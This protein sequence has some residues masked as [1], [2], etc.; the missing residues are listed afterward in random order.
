MAKAKRT[1]RQ[2]QQARDEERGWKATD[3]ILRWRKE[4]DSAGEVTPHIRAVE[5]RLLIVRTAIR[6]QLGGQP[7]PLLADLVFLL[8]RASDA[9][10][11]A[12]AELLIAV[13]DADQRA[14]IEAGLCEPTV[15]CDNC[16]HCNRC[17]HAHTDTDTDAPPSKLPN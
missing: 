3:R 9:S 10:I 15:D 12:L 13:A 5:G 17:F 4:L 14:L 6:L 8:D 2:T 11:P 16:N 1:Q 7:G